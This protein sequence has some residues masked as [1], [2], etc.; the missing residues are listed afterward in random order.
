ML[1]GVLASLVFSSVA[2]AATRHYWI[3]AERMPWNIVPSGRDPISGLTF[4]PEATTMEAIVYRRYTRRWG[5]PLSNLPGVAGDNDGIPGPTIRAR[6]G[7]TVLVHFRNADPTLPHSMHFHGFHYSFA[8]D[9]SFIPGE[10]GRAANVQPGRRATYRLH[11]RTSS[12]GVW[13]YHDHSSSMEASLA[14]GMYGAVSILGRR[15]RRPDREFIVFFAS[16][17]GFSTV[18]GRAFVGNTPTFRARVGDR[19]QWDV[20]AIGSEHHTFHLHG[21]RWTFAREFIDTRNVGPAESFRFRITEDNPGSWLYH[22]HVESH[23]VS[24]MVGLY[25][26]ARRARAGAGMTG[27]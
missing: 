7:D 6:V 13:P 27:R 20:L 12:V 3:Q 4:A 1:I 10:T 15:E 16:H 22:C 25:R 24:G 14:G 8:S 9:G 26:V 23:Q 2:D 19:V 5:R 18:N 11:A 17:M 21:H